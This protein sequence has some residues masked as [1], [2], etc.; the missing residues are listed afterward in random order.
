MN[1]KRVTI[2][3]L[4]ILLLLLLMLYHSLDYNSHDPELNYLLEHSEKYINTTVAFTGEIKT[5]SIINQTMII[6]LIKP[7][8]LTIT[9]PIKTVEDIPQQGDIIEILGVLTGHN[10]IIAQAVIIMERWKFDLIYIRSLPAIPFALYLF[11]RTWRF[12]RSKIV[13][14]RRDNKDA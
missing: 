5:I 14:E 8:T 7:S 10:Q 3:F 11:L 9:L 12:N 2:G 6:H 1:Y 4:L 13:F